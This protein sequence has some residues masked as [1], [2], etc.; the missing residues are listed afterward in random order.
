ML[1]SALASP[2]L[3]FHDRQ[4]LKAGS[5]GVCYDGAI[6]ELSNDGG[7]S[8][9]ALPVVLTD[10]FDGF[11]NAAFGNP[12]AGQQAW[13]GDPG[14]D[15]KSVID[16]AGHAGETVRFRFRIGHDR[17]PHRRG[18]NWTVDDVRVAGC[19]P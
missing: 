19:A 17:F 11:V 13:C 10:P 8:W 18:A 6:V 15:R 4:S 12:L 16:L 3:A 9:S 2:T 14:D 1:P 7:T 5:A